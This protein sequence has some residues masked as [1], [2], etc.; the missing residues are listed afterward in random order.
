[1]LLTAPALEKRAKLAAVPKLGV[2][3]KLASGKENSI[4]AAK[5]GSLILFFIGGRLYPVITDKRDLYS[6]E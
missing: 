1:V 6:G 3:A 4:T 2:C 5:T